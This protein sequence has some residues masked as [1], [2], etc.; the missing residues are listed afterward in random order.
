MN[1]N[2][3]V[4]IPERELRAGTRVLLSLLQHDHPMVQRAVVD[5]LGSSGRHEALG[6]V[7]RMECALLAESVP[8]EIPGS[9]RARRIVAAVKGFVQR[10]II[11]EDPF[12]DYR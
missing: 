8:G 6:C 5:A 3:L 11:A 2:V 10:N 7:V 9:T 1:P 12:G 4:A